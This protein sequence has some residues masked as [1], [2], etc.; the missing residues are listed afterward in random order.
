MSSE[1]INMLSQDM[2][3]LSIINNDLSIIDS[4]YNNNDNIF[5]YY[6][7][8]YEPNKINDIHLFIYKF[9]TSISLIEN[10]DLFHEY[11]LK[12]DHIYKRNISLHSSFTL[13]DLYIYSS[14][15]SKNYIVS[16]IIFQLIA[17]NVVNI[18]NKRANYRNL[19]YL[20]N[21][22]KVYGISKINE[23][24]YINDQ[25]N[26]EYKNKFIYYLNIVYFQLKNKVNNI[27]DNCKNKVLFFQDFDKMYMKTIDQF[28]TYVNKNIHIFSLYDIVSNND[29]QIIDYMFFIDYVIS[30]SNNDLYEILIKKI[31]N[32][33]NYT[34]NQHIN[35]FYM[36][37]RYIYSKDS[38]IVRIY[39][40][41]Y[42]NEHTFENV[43][44]LYNKDTKEE[45]LINYAQY[46]NDIIYFLNN[47]NTRI[48]DY[49]YNILYK[50]VNELYGCKKNSCVNKDCCICLDNINSSNFSYCSY[51]N[52]YYHTHCFE[53]LINTNF[54]C[55]LC[56]Q[57]LFSHSIQNI[58]FKYVFFKHILEHIVM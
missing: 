49:L 45:I 2:S 57:N 10:M 35:I 24:E 51:C 44:Y 47:L 16:Y 52:N 11:V 18:E 39:E 53:Q 28:Y 8:R 1:S 23:I 13:Y 46:I 7:N 54:K 41:K 20:N 56:R 29:E 58:E 40:E 37:I 22:L 32:N 15:I 21:I 4:I 6:T 55:A 50:Y 12:I 17:N 31:C 19:T 43:F 3:R 36:F 27:K 48:K 14:Y 26:F 34:Q 25:T 30:I 33:S 5:H 9:I 42:N 38:C